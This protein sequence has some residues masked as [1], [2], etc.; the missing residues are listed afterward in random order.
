MND[1]CTCG[2][3]FRTPDDHRDH[4]PCPGSVGEQL[5]EHLHRADEAI[6]E[7]RTVY[8]QNH[9]AQEW[10]D[11]LEG[12]LKDLKRCRGC[13]RFIMPKNYRIAD[14]CPCNNPRGINHGLVPKN[15][16]T[17]AEC[18]PEKTGGTRYPPEVT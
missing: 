7:M 17:C 13:D 8:A 16:C 4:M 9:H 14:G 6:K 1:T 12:H 11:F 18:D 2:E 15:T 10:A 5:A 3:N